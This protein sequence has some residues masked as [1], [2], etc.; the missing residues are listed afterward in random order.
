MSL[1]RSMIHE[2]ASGFGYQVQQVR[3][4]VEIG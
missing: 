2:F 4:L 3:L 1:H